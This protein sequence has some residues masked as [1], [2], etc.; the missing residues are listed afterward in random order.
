MK[1]RIGQYALNGST[2]IMLK[3]AQV[4]QYYVCPKCYQM[5]GVRQ[6]NM[7]KKHFYH[8]DYIQKLNMILVLICSCKN[9]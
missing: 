4:K 9:Y 5:I 8:L 3:D 7:R 6:G 2:L 1:C